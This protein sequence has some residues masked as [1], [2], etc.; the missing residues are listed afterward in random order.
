MSEF[1]KTISDGRYYANRIMP[2]LGRAIFVSDVVEA[3]GL[4]TMAVDKHWRLYYDPKVLKEWDLD[5]LSAVVI[6]ETFHLVF[7]HHRR[8]EAIAPDAK[9]DLAALWNIAADMAIN[10]ILEDTPKVKLPKG[11]VYPHT[12]PGH[13]QICFDPGLSAEEYF[14]L[15]QQLPPNVKQNLIGDSVDSGIGSISASGTDGQEREWELG[16]P[17][18]ASGLEE[19]TQR[20]VIRSSVKEMKDANSSSGRGLNSNEMS[21]VIEKI[22]EPKI[23]PAAEIFA[24]VKYA[25]NSIHGHGTQT[26]KRRNP[27]QP[28]GALVMP[29]NERPIPQVRVLIDTSGSMRE[30]S[31]LALAA[32]VVG[33]IINALPG[34]GVEVYCADTQVNDVQKVFTPNLITATGR[35]GTRMEVAIPQVDADLPRPDVIVCIT[36]GETAWPTKPTNAKLIICLTR[37]HCDTPP[38]WSKVIS[39]GM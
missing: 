28:K 36:D 18:E 4:Q 39:I 9:E 17:D 7:D 21:T 15:L 24:S 3:P 34:E 1:E 19:T 26:Y 25:V 30:D 6:H 11:C 20:R 13:E 16:A 12:V 33:K 8:F 2:Y 23:D 35:G 37:E 27:R 31:D 32:G 5:E 22:L 14:R 29:A 10:S 38:S